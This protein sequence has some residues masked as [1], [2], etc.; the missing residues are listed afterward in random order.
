MF[1]IGYKHGITMA[2]LL[3]WSAPALAQSLY[4]TDSS[5]NKVQYG[6][7]NGAGP[8]YD[9]FDSTDGISSPVG[10]ALDEANGFV[11]FSDGGT[12]IKRGNIDGTGT[13]ITLFNASDGLVNAR[14]LAIDAAGERIFWADRDAMKIQVGNINGLGSPITL[15]D[16]DDDLVSG[17]WDIALD[18]AGGFIYW[19]NGASVSKGSINGWGSPIELFGSHIPI[20]VA[21][22]PK[23]G[24]VF[25]AGFE[26]YIMSGNSDG[27]GTPTVMFER[28]HTEPVMNIVHDPHSKALYWTLGWTGRIQGGSD[29]G[30][31]PVIELYTTADGIVFPSNLAVTSR[32]PPPL[33][34]P[35]VPGH[36]I[37]W[38]GDG[39][40]YSAHLGGFDDPTVLYWKNGG[41]IAAIGIVANFATGDLY[42]TRG[43][44]QGPGGYAIMRGSVDGSVAPAVLFDNSSDGISNPKGLAADF[45]RGKLYWADGHYIRSGNIDGSGYP[46]LLYGNHPYYINR[47]NDV[48]LDIIGGKIFWTDRGTTHDPSEPPRITVG[49]M[50]GFGSP[51]ILFDDSDGLSIPYGIAVDVEAGLLYW[52]DTGTAKI[53]VG[54]IDGSG[55]PTVL[56][57][58]AD[59]FVEPVGITL[60]KESGMLYI[61]DSETGIIAVAKS[62]GAGI[63][64]LYGP[65]DGLAHSLFVTI[66]P[67][68]QIPFSTEGLPTSNPKSLA[69]SVIA[70]IAAASAVFFGTGLRRRRRTA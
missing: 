67:A 45:T 33:P 35:L 21:V 1:S 20:G 16:E 32:T 41:T 43:G 50:D 18:I 37:Y 57:T 55:S 31:G 8:P 13:P 19:A 4:W 7:T 63:T 38:T 59:G 12:T 58:S 66:N 46:E 10:I 3:L 40:I 49:R 39:K 54:N 34:P 65:S 69:L 14:G 44:G 56:Y 11:Y 68:P 62:D 25:W 52:S 15:F 64:E 42:W 29:S 47:S 51:S 70:I 2:A 48:A 27:S 30:V 36:K 6:E 17:P 23:A 5:T 61:S 9:L 24:K 22:D 60:N 28:P 53:H 26:G